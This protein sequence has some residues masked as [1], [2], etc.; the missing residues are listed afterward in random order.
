MLHKIKNVKTE[1]LLLNLLYEPLVSGTLPVLDH[2]NVNSEVYVMF[3]I[4][5]FSLA[6]QYSVNIKVLSNYIR[7]SYISSL[8]DFQNLSNSFLKS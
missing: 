5:M 7:K 3:H 8:A 6:S 1:F 4:A 2:D